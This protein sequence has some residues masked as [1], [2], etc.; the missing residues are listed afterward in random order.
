MFTCLVLA[1]YVG[2]CIRFQ[3]NTEYKRHDG[4]CRII[5]INRRRIEPDEINKTD[6]STLYVCV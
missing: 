1:F 6:R 2:V 4:N 5:M 3:E